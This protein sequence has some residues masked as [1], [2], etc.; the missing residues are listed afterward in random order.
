MALRQTPG[1]PCLGWD[2]PSLP[3][4][5]LGQKEVPSE[6][7]AGDTPRKA[8]SSSDTSIHVVLTPIQHKR[9]PRLADSGP[10]LPGNACGNSGGS[11][12][13]VC[14]PTGISTGPAQLEGVLTY[15]MDV[16]ACAFLGGF[17]V[18]SCI[19]AQYMCVYTY[20]HV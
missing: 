6:P 4:R 14:A 15:G 2:S 17:N 8:S 20:G 1:C 9:T 11:L 16:C 7:R 12:C 13:G 19:Q 5:T 10:S 3:P 18:H